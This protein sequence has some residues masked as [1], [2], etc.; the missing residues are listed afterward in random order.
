MYLNLIW[1]TVKIER[2]AAESLTSYQEEQ[3]IRARN[4]AEHM[5]AI[6]ISELAS[7]V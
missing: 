6:A 7:R 1:F 5:Q 4:E 3:L 2:S